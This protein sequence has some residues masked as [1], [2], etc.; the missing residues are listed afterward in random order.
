MAQ[1]NIHQSNSPIYKINGISV[2]SPNSLETQ[3]NDV[4]RSWDN[5]NAILVQKPIR[6]RKQVTWTYTAMHEDTLKSFYTDYVRKHI[7]ETGSMF[8]TI[9]TPYPGMGNIDM[10]CYLGTPTK[11]KAVHG[12]Y[13]GVVYWEFSLV[14]TEVEGISLEKKV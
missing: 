10:Y 1:D 9:T 2:P 12:K 6:Y 7:E 4:S 3:D 13:E 14:W 11:F 5:M 8:F